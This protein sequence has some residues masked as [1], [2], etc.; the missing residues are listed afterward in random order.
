MNNSENNKDGKERQSIIPL[1]KMANSIGSSLFE[2]N[3]R[4]L[5]WDR[6]ISGDGNIRYS[7]TQQERP[8][9]PKAIHFISL[10]EGE[11]R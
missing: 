1:S 9:M 5:I 10:G 8:D 2:G 6:E 11:K 7:D 4:D 3:D